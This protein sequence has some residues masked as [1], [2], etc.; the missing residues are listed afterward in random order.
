[1]EDKEAVRSHGPQQDGQR[2]GEGRT[3]G[4][5]GGAKKVLLLKFDDGE[6]EWDG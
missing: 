1:M 3:L 4:P 6:V 2:V 5:N